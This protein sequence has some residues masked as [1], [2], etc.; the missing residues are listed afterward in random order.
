MDMLN[1]PEEIR[2]VLAFYD[3]EEQKMKSTLANL[4]ANGPEA[5][6]LDYKRAYDQS[7][8]AMKVRR[9]LLK[10]LLQEDE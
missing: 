4:E 3:S 9:R 7:M 8:K 10:S 6:Y 1:S 2:R 5:A